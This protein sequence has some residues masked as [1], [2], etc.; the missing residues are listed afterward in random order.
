LTDIAIVIARR[1]TVRFIR[2]LIADRH[3]QRRAAD[4]TRTTDRD[5]GLRDCKHTST[6]RIA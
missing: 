5:M 2:D 1:S 3:V 4:L 6:E